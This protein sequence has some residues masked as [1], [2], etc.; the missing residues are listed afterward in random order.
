MD[1]ACLIAEAC[2]STLAV[3]PKLAPRFKNLIA[4]ILIR[5]TVSRRWH[6]GLHACGSP[7]ATHCPHWLPLSSATI[8]NL[9]TP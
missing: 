5:A 6:Y 9:A 4:F 2:W 7:T 1:R 8:R 3:R